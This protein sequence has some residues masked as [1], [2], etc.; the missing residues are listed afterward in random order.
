VN[1]FFREVASFGRSSYTLFAVLWI[2]II[3][4]PNTCI[5]ALGA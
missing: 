4:A 5:F 2:E 3:N 1:K